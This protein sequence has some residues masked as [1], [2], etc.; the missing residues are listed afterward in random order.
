MPSGRRA[1]VRERPVDDPPAR[2][3]LRRSVARPG[4]SSSALLSKGC[5]TKPCC[6]Y[7]SHSAADD[8]LGGGGHTG[9][10]RVPRG[11]MGRRAVPPRR[12]GR[13]AGAR[14]RN[15]APPRA[16]R[17]DRR[18]RG[19]PQGAFAA[20]EGAL[21]P[22]ARPRARARRARA[23]HG[24]RHRAPPPPGRRAR[25]HAHRADRRE[26][27]RR[28]AGERQ[29]ARRARAPRSSPSRKRRTRTRT[30]RS[31]SPPGP[32]SSSS[33]RRP[34]GPEDDPGRGPPLPLPPPDRVRQDDRGRGLRRGG[35]HPRRPDPH[36]PAPARLAVRARPEDR[37][38]RRPLRRR[39]RARQGAAARATR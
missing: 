18:D 15:G 11:S 19:G 5:S 24:R 17:G 12:R 30:K 25:R 10:R 36:A 37:G 22:P 14:V 32:T 13:G 20:V 34:P 16:R 39:D 35:A 3:M 31:S 4:E 7:G 27:A 33:R 29:R 28:G 1:L 23:A 26:P 9:C 21:R 6:A 2:G 8:R 38:L